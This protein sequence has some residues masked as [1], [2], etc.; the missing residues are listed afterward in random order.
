[1]KHKKIITLLLAMVL[2]TII[3]GAVLNIIVVSSNGGMPTIGYTASIDRW[4][5]IDE[6]TKYSSLSDIIHIGNY[7]LSF[8]DLFI[9]A[10]A[11]ICPILLWIALPRGRKLLPLFIVNIIGVILSRA[12][13]HNAVPTLLFMLAAIGCV[14]IMYSKYREEVA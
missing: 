4:V 12:I 7:V 13:P 2:V 9:L 6:A 10:G 5:P 11:A 3:V 8:G 14:L 1:M